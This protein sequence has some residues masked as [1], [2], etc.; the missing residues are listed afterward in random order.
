VN[1]S[2]HNPLYP[3]VGIDSNNPINVNF[4]QEPFLFDASKIGGDNR[5]KEVIV[6]LG[7]GGKVKRSGYRK[8]SRG[9]AATM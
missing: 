2:L 8:R 7:L 5:E 1:V 9:R 6:R 4:G 3:T